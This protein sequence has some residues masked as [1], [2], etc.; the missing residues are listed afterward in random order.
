VERD[1]YLRH[2]AADGARMAEIARTADLARPVPTCPEWT[3]RD[4]LEHTGGVHRWQTIV[5]RDAL[6]REPWPLPDDVRLRPD[7]DVAEWFQRGVDEAVDGMRT[8]E[9][10]DA[11]W[12]WFPPDQTAGW[13]FRRIT[14][15]TLVHRVDAELAVGAEARTPMDP[16][17]SVD[18]IDEFVDVFIPA[19]AMEGQRIGGTGQTLHLHATDAA[20]EWLL[21]MHEASVDVQRGHAKGDAAVRGPA[22]ELLLFA[23]GRDPSPALEVLGDPSVVAAYTTAARI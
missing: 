5:V 19:A 20:G 18:G 1:V 2:L 21:T 15:E 14:Q 11:R 10:G 17:L 23:W 6:D 13:Y 4:L 16:A 7:E 9:A 3:L 12:T 8:A 22:G